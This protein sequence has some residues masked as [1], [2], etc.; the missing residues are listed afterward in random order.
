MVRAKTTGGPRCNAWSP[1]FGIGAV[2]NSSASAEAG[3]FGKSGQERTIAMSL[4]NV[5]A[6]EALAQARME[7]SAWA[8]YQSGSDDEVT[9]RENRAAFERV[10]LRPRMLVDV[11]TCDT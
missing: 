1:H 10:R 8:F 9:L 11:E 2:K 5:F 4:V 6:Y 3:T 7:P